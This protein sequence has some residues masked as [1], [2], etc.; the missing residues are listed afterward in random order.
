MPKVKMPRSAPSLDMTPLVDLAFLLVTFFILTSSFRQPEPVTVDPP[1]STTIEQIPKQVFLITIDKDG[2]TF[3]DI[4]NPAIKGKVFFDMCEKYNIKITKQDSLKFVG[5]ASIGLKM[6]GIMDY[7]EKEPADRAGYPMTGIPYDTADTKKG[8]LYW[9]AY[10]ARI[11]AKNDF[12][13]RKAEAEK[14]KL[15]FD[16]TSALKFSVKADSRTKYDVVQSVIQVFRDVKIKNFEMITGLE[17]K[18]AN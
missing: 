11:A 6:S 12:E 18:P 15:E 8:Q 2:R 10:Y 17:D 7:L 3:V 5:T 1:T 14:R 13:D 16:M 9:W 4:T